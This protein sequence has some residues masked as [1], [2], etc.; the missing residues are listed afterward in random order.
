MATHTGARTRGTAVRSGRGCGRRDRQ[1]FH[2][3]GRVRNPFTHTESHSH[4]RR[5][6][7]RSL[8]TY[9]EGLKARDDVSSINT[10]VREIGMM[11]DP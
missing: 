3:C 5:G 1:G 2:P 9:E 8:H 11:C 4:I 6:S 10:R 7:Q